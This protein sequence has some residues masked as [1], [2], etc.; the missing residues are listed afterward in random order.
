MYHRGH[1]IDLGQIWVLGW[2][3]DRRAPEGSRTASPGPPSPRRAT[4]PPG[5]HLRALRSTYAMS[6]ARSVAQPGDRPRGPG[7]S[8]NRRASAETD[9]QTRRSRPRCQ[10]APAGAA[11]TI[12]QPGPGHALDRR[13]EVG[14]RPML[15]PGACESICALLGIDLGCKPGPEHA[16]QRARV[17]CVM[18][19][20]HSPYRPF[21]PAPVKN[22]LIQ[23]LNRV[24]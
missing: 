8:P 9:R 12:C 19:V 21:S 22:L 24:V 4:A 23:V 14:A 15:C 18:V 1:T 16:A 2:M 11:R 6:G 5:R 7:H 13:P 10:Q 17:Q 20:C 3:T